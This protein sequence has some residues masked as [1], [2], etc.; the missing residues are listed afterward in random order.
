MPTP[1][2]I[3]ALREVWGHQPLLLPGVSGV[4]LRGD[5]GQEQVLLGRR[6]DNGRWSIPAGIVEPDEQPADCVVRELWEETRVRVAVERLA[7]V[8]AEGPIT[9]PNGDVCQYISMTFRCR[10]L[11]GEA[12]VGDDESLE[13][14]WFAPD[15]L[16][17]DFSTLSA[18]KLERATSYAGTAWFEPA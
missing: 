13:V 4:V 8:I 6:A 5:P 16:P 11:S 12:A 7:S 15:D 9:Y 18:T 14:G 10:Y 2:Y 1:A 3:A 17:A